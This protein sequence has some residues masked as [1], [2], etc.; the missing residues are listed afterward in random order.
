MA[1]VAS[2]QEWE[3]SLDDRHRLKEFKLGA[4]GKPVPMTSLGMMDVNFRGPSHTFPY[5]RVTDLFSQSTEAS[6][7]LDPRS[8]LGFDCK[9]CKDTIDDQGNRLITGDKSEIF[10]DAL[11]LVGLTATGVYDMRAFPFDS[12]TAGVEGHAN[13]LDNLLSSDA[14]TPSSV[15]NTWVW[16]L[17]LMTVG[18]LLFSFFTHKVESI[19]AL[20]IFL[21]SAGGFAVFDQKVLF[22]GQLHNVNTALLYLEF[23]TLFIFTLA[24]RYVME[25]KN[26]KFIKGAFSKY[27]AP[28]I[29]DSILKDPSKLTVGGEKRDLTILF[30]DV[31]GFTT[32]S[33]KMDAKALSSFLNDYL[34][35]MTELVF[36][37]EGTL[38]KYIGD[39]VMAFWGAPVHQPKHALNCCNAAV[40]MMKTLAEHRER[41]LKTYGVDVQIGIGINSGTVSVGNMGSERIFEYTVIGDSVNLA[42]RLEGLTKEYGVPILTTRFTLDE[43]QKSGETVPPHRSIVNVKVKGKRNAVELIQILDRA[44]SMDGLILFNEARQHFEK[45]EWDQAITKFKAANELLAGSDGEPDGPSEWFVA[46]CQEFRLH[47]PDT[48]WDGSWEMTSK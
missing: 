15:G 20:A 21:L 29:V 7:A 46:R 32:L 39:A 23:T 2:G 30:S 9:G 24:I 4:T 8:K 38:D 14:M 33:E 25:E 47:P 34:G 18:A 44:Y 43:I 28:A 26:K 17:L 36:Q 31:R 42:S 3:L 45:K 22:E 1:S 16:I 41:F 6:I 10:K 5:V 11:V 40:K 37:H 12:N 35:L 27:V 13:I 19:P 48:D